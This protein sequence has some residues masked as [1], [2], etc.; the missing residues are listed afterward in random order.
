MLDRLLNFQMGQFFFV[1]TQ[2]SIVLWLQ[3]ILMIIVHTYTQWFIGNLKWIN[4]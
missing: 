1:G 2:K 4:T 3:M